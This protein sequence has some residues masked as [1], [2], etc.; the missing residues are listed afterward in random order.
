[1]V[2][3]PPAVRGE[4]ASWTREYSGEATRSCAARD[5]AS[6]AQLTGRHSPDDVPVPGP[7]SGPGGGSWPPAKTPPSCRSLARSGQVSPS[8]PSP[9]PPSTRRPGT[10]GDIAPCRPIISKVYRIVV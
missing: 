10:S 5:L 2:S 8:A 4:P 9:I 6:A 3:S 1:M 7:G